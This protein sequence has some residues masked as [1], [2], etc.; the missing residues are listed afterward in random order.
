MRT[1][2]LI[3]NPIHCLLTPIISADGHIR[4]SL[5]QL[6][7]LELHHLYSSLYDEQN[8]N[9]SNTS[10]LTDIQGFTEWVSDTTPSISVGWDW[11]V[12]YQTG[13][14][15]YSMMGL[16]FSNLLLKNNQEQDFS[17]DESMSMLA[18]WLNSLKWQEKLFEYIQSKYA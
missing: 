7:N 11:Q 2:S 6:A 16:P 17:I 18:I 15:G 13:T 14:T 5:Q 10:S 8:L 9:L 3:L 1:T 12:H 4:L